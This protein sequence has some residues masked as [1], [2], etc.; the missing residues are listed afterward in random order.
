MEELGEI[1]QEN[2]EQLEEEGPFIPW[3]REA[4][5]EIW[6]KKGQALDKFVIQ[7]YQCNRKTEGGKSE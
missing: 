4:E 5:V 7:F 2:R 6:I 3:G 1:N